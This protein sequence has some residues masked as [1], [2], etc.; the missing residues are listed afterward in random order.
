MG[1][2]LN[3][4]KSCGNGVRFNANL[5]QPLNEL[6][7]QGAEGVILGCTELGLL[8]KEQDIELPIFDTTIIH[9]QSAV[10]LA[11]Q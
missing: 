6:Q 1:H 8:I 10:E 5:L 7:Q 4:S 3:S 9:A 11:L 2:H